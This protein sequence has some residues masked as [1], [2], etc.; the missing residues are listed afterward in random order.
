MG[1]GALR[2]KNH[3]SSFQI[4]I[5]FGII[6]GY[7]FFKDR[8][9]SLVIHLGVCTPGSQD[10][11]TGGSVCPSLYWYSWIYWPDCGRGYHFFP[12]HVPHKQLLRV[13]CWLINL[14]F[15]LFKQVTVCYTLSTLCFV[16]KKNGCDQTWRGTTGNNPVLWDRGWADLLG[17]C[18][19]HSCFSFHKVV[20]GSVG[21]L[22]TK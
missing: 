12:L 17:L 1:L 22:D 14:S 13:T 3:A 7:N 8:N 4:F 18:M 21:I 5:E 6:F 2:W 9:V 20:R 16:N 19:F 15:Q 10:F 11:I